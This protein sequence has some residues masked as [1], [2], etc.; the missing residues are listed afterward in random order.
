M[1]ERLGYHHQS[2]KKLFECDIFLR[3]GYGNEQGR[4]PNESQVAKVNVR[5]GVT[6]LKITIMNKG[7]VK[8][9]RT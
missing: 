1:F 7:D 6:I 2:N 4:L 5:E 3:I 9:A 8:N